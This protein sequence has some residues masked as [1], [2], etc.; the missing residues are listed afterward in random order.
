MWDMES[1]YRS[2]SAELTR[3]CCGLCRN[4]TAAQ[5]L[6]QEVF[7]RALKNT[8]ILEELGPNQ[9]RAWLYTAA[10]NLFVDQVRRAALERS[11]VETQREDAAAEEPGFTAVELTQLL[12]LL[13]PKERT[14]F[15]MRYLEGYNATELG[16][17]YGEPPAT[18]RARLAKARRLLQQ[19]LTEE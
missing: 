4:W 13:P 14:L 16:E 2:Y 19:Q 10:R 8:H 9:R 3:Y 1:F 15:R 18:I 5:D 6:A 12:R 11:F 17:L 7:Y